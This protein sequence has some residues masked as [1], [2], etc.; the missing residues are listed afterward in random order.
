[1][2]EQLPYGGSGAQRRFLIRLINVRFCAPQDAGNPPA[3]QIQIPQWLSIKD[4]LSPE[5]GHE[6]AWALLLWLNTP[7]QKAKAIKNILKLWFIL[8]S[9]KKCFKIYL[10]QINPLVTKGFSRAK[11][12]F[13]SLHR[14]FVL[15]QFHKCISL[16]LNN[17]IIIHWGCPIRLFPTC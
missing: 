15:N 12:M 6:K 9:Y 11:H 5:L 17:I 3:A 10:T 1:M 16:Q 2:D 4:W 13:N 7:T 8:P 14:A